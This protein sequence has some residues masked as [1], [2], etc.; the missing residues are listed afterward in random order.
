[1]LLYTCGLRRRELIR[2]TIEDYDPKGHT[3]FIRE[4]KFHKSRLLPLSNDG[5]QEIEDLLDVRHA[6]HL[7]TG[8]EAPLIWNRSG[9]GSP[10]TGHGIG[11]T[12]RELLQ[13]TGIRTAAGRL[14]RVHDFR[15]TFA[16]H[17]LLRWYRAGHDVQTKLPFLA[18]YMGH[19]SIVSTAY[20]LRFIDQL[21]ACAS[22][23][24][25]QRYGALIRDSTVRTDFGD[26]S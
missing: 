17:A 24:F 11:S 3:L 8:S 26:D 4:S 13:T 2:L 15:H 18:A 22:E 5:V 6:R 20:Y 16:V 10:Y 23:R 21:A 7:A 25:S 12:I 19:I 14:P 1:V 9:G